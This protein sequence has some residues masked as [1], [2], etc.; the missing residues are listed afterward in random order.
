M[1][2]IKDEQDIQKTIPSN[3]NENCPGVESDNAGKSSACDGCE[4][5]KFCQER[6]KGPDPSISE[7]EERM[8]NV[9]HKIIVLSG[10]KKFFFFLFFFFSFFFFFTF[11][12]FL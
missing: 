4:N 9:K 2:E 5:Q 3:A 1:E 12:F 10:K 11:F 6:P 7:I 8:K